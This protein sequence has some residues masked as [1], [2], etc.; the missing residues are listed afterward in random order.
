MDFGTI[1]RDLPRK[2]ICGVAQTSHETS[3]DAMRENGRMY[4]R[5]IILVTFKYG[6]P[7]AKTMGQS[8][9]LVNPSE[10]RKQLKACDSKSSVHVSLWSAPLMLA[11]TL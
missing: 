5:G 7:E 2:R 8:V 6:Q 9:K 4:I 3:K 1:R 10:A 11:L